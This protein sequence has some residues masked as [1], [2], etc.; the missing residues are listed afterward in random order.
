MANLKKIEFKKEVLETVTREKNLF[1]YISKVRGH[2]SRAY[3]V[4]VISIPDIKDRI[5]FAS[6]NKSIE[7]DLTVVDAITDVY[8][9]A[10]ASD[11]ALV[12]RALHSLVNSLQGKASN[13]SIF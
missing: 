12:S 5:K 3:N 7:I 1:A 2:L 6:D 8:N 11:K 4:L 10:V 9:N 13:T